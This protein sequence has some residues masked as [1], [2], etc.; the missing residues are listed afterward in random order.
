MAGHFEPQQL[1]SE[2]ILA[3]AHRQADK[4]LS[5][6]SIAVETLLANATE[7]ARVLRVE[8][9]AAGDAEARRRSTLL[10]ATVPIELRREHDRCFEAQLEEIRHKSIERLQSLSAEELQSALT[11]LAAEALGHFVGCAVTVSLCEHDH[12]SFGE[13]LQRELLERRGTGSEPLVVTASTTTT[14]SGP[15]VADVDGRRTWDNRLLV[16]LDRLWPELRRQ[17]AAQL[18]GHTAAASLTDLK[19]D[20]PV[21]SG[22]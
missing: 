5:E 1:L 11:Q 2:A 10:L 4:C 15:L 6:A 7:E 14:D 20:A 19:R 18:P 22:P 16:R 17:L 13:Q 12:Q 21:G 9:L 8:A 3:E